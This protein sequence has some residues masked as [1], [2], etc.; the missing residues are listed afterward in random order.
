MMSFRKE[1]GVV[2]VGKAGGLVGWL[3]GCEVVELSS[4]SERS[5][6][7]RSPREG[8]DIVVV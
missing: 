8:L 3:E 6:M 2:V 1:S 4:S 7:K 5:R